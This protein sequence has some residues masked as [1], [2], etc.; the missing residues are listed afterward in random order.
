MVEL[1]L[2]SADSSIIVSHAICFSS[3]F[4]ITVLIWGK[5]YNPDFS[6]ASGSFYY[7]NLASHFNLLV[8]RNQ[9]KK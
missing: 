1:I 6:Y 7:K 2:H 5:Y 3:H 9:C 4:V 8:N